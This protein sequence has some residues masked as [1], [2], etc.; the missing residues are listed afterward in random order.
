MTLGIVL[1]GGAEDFTAEV[2]SVIYAP[3]RVFPPARF[4]GQR[5][6]S[7]CDVLAGTQQPQCDSSIDPAWGAGAC[8]SVKLLHRAP[9]AAGYVKRAE[10]KECSVKWRHN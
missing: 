5:R 1:Y 9:K 4:R 8:Y 7:P 6:R 2:V 10:N 3:G